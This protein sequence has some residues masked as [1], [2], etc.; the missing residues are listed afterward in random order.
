[1]TAQNQVHIGNLTLGNDLPLAVIAGPCV[2]ES[3]DL[4]TSIALRLRELCS[5][6]DVPLIFKASF[7]KANRTSASAVRGPGFE[8]R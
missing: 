5:S 1:M 6:L 3:L 2:L 8:Q 7:D 4:A